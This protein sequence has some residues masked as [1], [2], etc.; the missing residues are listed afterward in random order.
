MS[1]LME[2]LIERV[3][4]LAAKVGDLERLEHPAILARYSTDAG[5]SIP[6]SMATIVNFEDV[7]YDQNSLVTTGA[8]WKFTAATAG[9]YSVVLMIMFAGTNTWVDTEDGALYLYKNGAVFSRLDRKDNYSSA[10]SVYM[11]LGG[12]DVV[13]LA[14]GDTMDVRAWQTSGAALALNNDGTW[15]HVAIWKV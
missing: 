15:N 14:V 7:T 10:S 11:A 4:E 3:N 5:Q 2:R 1:E 13:Y 12:G 9:Y 6:D 8:G